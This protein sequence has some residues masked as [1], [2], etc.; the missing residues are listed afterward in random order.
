MPDRA[1]PC[2]ICQSDRHALLF[3]K[4]GVEYRECRHCG[5]RFSRPDSNPN[6]TNA[7]ADFETAYLKY[8]EPDPAD[9]VNFAWLLAWM[10]R[11]RPIR[12]ARVLDIG[13]ASGKLVRHL[14]RC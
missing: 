9:G 13:A 4:R 1:R 11:F 10:E 8:L 5:F 7:I 6:L 2:A 14:L 12:G 3:V